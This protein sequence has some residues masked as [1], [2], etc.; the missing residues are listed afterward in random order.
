MTLLSPLKN[1]SPGTAYDK[2]LYKKPARTWTEALPIGNGRLGA[3]VFGG[4][5]K[6]RLQLNESSLVSGYPGYRELPLDAGK[7]F[8]AITAAIA[9]GQ[10]AEATRLVEG[11]WLGGCW[12]CYQPLGD[13]SVDFAKSGRPRNYERELDIANGICRVS[14][15]AE[16]VRFT[17]EIF[18]SHPDEVIVLRFAS[19][20]AGRLDFRVRLGSPHP[21]EV[22]AGGAELSMRGQAPGFVLRRTLEWVEERGD[23]WK[24]PEL[25]DEAGRRLPG[26]AQVL[27]NGR[28]MCFDAR[29]AVQTSGGKMSAGRDS[30]AVSGAS[31]TVIIFTAATSY[32]G[33]DKDPVSE[34]ADAGGKAGGYLRRAL[35]RDVRSLGKRH[36]ADHRRLFER[37]ALDLGPAPDPPTDQRLKEPGPALAALYFQFARYL[38][39]AGSRGN[40]QPLNLQGIW[41]EEIIPPW[42][43]QYTLNINAEMNY[44]PAEVCNLSECAEPFRR[45]V[46]ELAVDGRRVAR[47]MYGRRGWVAHHNTTLWREAQPVD[48][49]AV[50][51][52]WP[53]GAA[54]LCVELFDHYRFGCDVAFLR[55]A[56]P[57][58]KGACLFLLDWMVPNGEG[59]LVTPVSTSPENTFHYKVDEKEVIGSISAGSTM[60]MSIIRE[61]FQNTVEAAAVLAVDA[62]FRRMLKT[63]LGRLLP[64]RIGARG[65]LQEWQE[66]LMETEADHRHVSQLFGLHPAAQITR[67]GTPELAAAA[68]RTLELRG[69]GGTG[70]SK[71]WKISFWARL[72]DGDHAYKMLTELL[73]ESTLPNLFDTC[74]PFQIDGNFGGA[75]GMAEMLLQSH[76]GEIELLPA[77]PAAWPSGS[78]SG[79]RAR[80]GYEVGIRWSDGR[81]DEAAIRADRD[82][83]CRV[84]LG[85]KARTVPVKAGGWLRLNENLERVSRAFQDIL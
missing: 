51:A 2:L 79:L 54:W 81:L 29:V 46:G 35:K 38:L 39:I 77:L 10:Y 34:G 55:E 64:F 44:W 42:S 52:Y 20:K 32:N 78:V 27:Y 18:A 63:A 26:A 31:E 5:A 65:Q 43:G 13:L 19:D 11:V 17:R 69:D 24:Y 71:A 4:V 21:V 75:A 28:G 36:A 15:E 68:R 61:L 85:A 37:V 47:K 48:N 49:T 83:A 16:G 70:W 66:D 76:D 58:M 23:T 72:G 74:P 22:R 8:P 7:D 59:R 6:E 1:S 80:G 30:I 9:A 84:R 56:Y 50:A 57:L 25:W 45:M 40:G 62:G 12:A 14:Y 3:M 41:N 33:F 67:R 53:L 73:K 60:D 82:G